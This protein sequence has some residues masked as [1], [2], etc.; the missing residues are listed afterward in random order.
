[1]FAA[2]LA[3]AL[4]GETAVAG[5]RA[6]RAARR[7]AQVDPRADGVGALGLLLG[8]A[9]GEH[10]GGVRGAEHPD[11]LAEPGHR[12]AREA[13]HQFRPVGHGGGPGFGPAGGAGGDE[14][15]VGVPLGD[16][17][18]QQAEREREVGAGTRGEVQVGLVG[19]AGAAR[20]DDDQRA[21]VLLQLGEVAQ[22]GWH[23]LGKVGADQ[24][25]A[26]G[27]RYVLQGEGQTPV[28]AEGALVGGGGRG[29]AE[30]AVVVDLRGPQ[31]DPG[32]LAERVGLFVG[33]PAAA[34]HPDGVRPVGAGRAG[35]ALGDGVEGLLPGG[36]CQL[37]GVG[38]HQRLG[39]AHPGGEHGGG[40][41][42]L[43]AQRAPVDGEV[44]ALLHHHARAHALRARLGSEVHTALQ[45]AVRAV[46]GDGSARGRSPGR[47]QPRGAASAV[48]GA[49]GVDVPRVHTATLRPGCYAGRRA[50]LR[51]R[52]GGLSA[53]FTAR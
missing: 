40:G 44:R 49:G 6:A 20:V 1:M 26:A 17:E 15:L 7:Q 39:Q 46:R 12:N 33:E 28:E 27:A 18:V 23:G 24:D 9:G 4:A 5:V 45:G 36:R 48:G 8:P 30:A 21:A 47:A 2:A 43:A 52:F 41:A 16:H 38:A 11:R 35:Q 51:L 53:R 19:G 42:P 31:G 50:P 22:G 13:F 14:L 25:H 10:H 34:E 29:H 37:P 3:V 32:E